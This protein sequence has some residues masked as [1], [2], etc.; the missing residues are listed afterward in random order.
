[1]AVTV[2]A[3]LRLNHT[4]AD[5]AVQIHFEIDIDDWRTGIVPADAVAMSRAHSRQ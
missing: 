5:N 2:L 3:L 4:L 1:M